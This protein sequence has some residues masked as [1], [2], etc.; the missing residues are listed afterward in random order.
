MRRLLSVLLLLALALS[1]A[2]CGS[3]SG[4]GDESSPIA[5]VVVTPAAETAQPEAGLPTPKVTD[6]PVDGEVPDSA[7]PATPEDLKAIAESFV[8]RPV[9]ELYAAIGEP[10]S[11]DY[12]PSCLGPGE[13][14]E[15]IYEGFTVYTYREN[16]VETVNVVR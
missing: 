11:A 8:T 16:G 9:E 5:P 6:S 4:S 13:D 14:G 1:L 15:L 2:A 10:D 7:I 12:G 3:K